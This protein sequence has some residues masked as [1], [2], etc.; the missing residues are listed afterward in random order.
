MPLPA[1]DDITTLVIRTDFSD[2]AAW[3]ALQR[4][5]DDGQEFSAA[6]YVDDRRFAGVTVEALVAED[7]AAEDEDRTCEV[8]LADAVALG[9][10]AFPLLAVDLYAEPGRTF[11]LPA[12]WFPEI[13]VNLSL[14]NLD[15]S[16]YADTA[17]P[18]GVFRGFG[19]D[20]G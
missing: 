13:S 7:A 5:L 12:R 3:A 20:A 1:A 8:C 10:P 9:D 16:D 18:S 4:A 19:G 14:A 15:F 6:T 2:D 11:R 17:D